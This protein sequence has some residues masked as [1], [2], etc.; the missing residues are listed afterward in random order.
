VMRANLARQLD[1]TPRGV[2]VSPRTSLFQSYPSILTC[3]LPPIHRFG[4]RTGV[5]ELHIPSSSSIGSHPLFSLFYA[6]GR[7]RRRWPKKLPPNFSTN[8]RHHRLTLQTRKRVLVRTARLHCSGALRRPPT[9]NVPPFLLLFLLRPVT[10]ST[11]PATL[12]P[13]HLFPP[14]DTT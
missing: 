8:N 1:M 10:V 14:F 6:G 7:K 11:R 9:A 5:P 4:S 3:L 2:Q 12:S 13:P